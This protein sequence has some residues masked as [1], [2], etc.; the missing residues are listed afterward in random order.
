MR[1]FWHALYA[2]RAD[3]VLN[4]HDH[5]YERFAPQDPAGRRR[6]RGIRQFVVGTGGR[7]HYPLK[8][9]KSNS[10]V[11]DGETFG[12]LRLQ[13]RPTSYRLRFLRAEGSFTDAGAGRCR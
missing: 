12:V 13:L 10:Q 2:A 1:P 4:G 6:A 3:L 8:E 7:S 5:T 11:F 9:R